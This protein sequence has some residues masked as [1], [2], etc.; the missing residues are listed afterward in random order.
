[1]TDPTACDGQ[2]RK[3]VGGEAGAAPAPPGARRFSCVKCAA[4]LAFQPGTE[5]VACP[6]CGAVNAVP[7]GAGDSFLR[8]NDFLAALAEE[9]R[10]QNDRSDALDALRCPACGAV[11][12][13]TPDRTSDKCPYCGS[14]L[15]AQNR[16]NVKLNVQALLPFGVPSG[17]AMGIYRRWIASRW[18]APADFARRATREQ[19]LDG[20]YMPYWTYDADTA[21]DY[22][23]QRGDVYYALETVYAMENG[24]QVPRQRQV[25][26][27][28]WSSAAGTVRVVFDD[29]LVPATR[30]LPAHLAGRLEPWNLDKLVPFSQDYLAGFVTESYQSSLA[31]GFQEAKRRM[32]P[33]IAD[34]V[35]EDIG[36]DEQRIDRMQTAYANITFKHILLPIWL[37]AYA[38]GGRTYRFMINAQTGEICGDRPWSAWKIALAAAAGL[39]AVGLALYYFS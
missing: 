37:S 31:D 11:T 34:A 4:A 14:A 36:G 29:V 21:T 30:S 20:I 10:R 32:E 35:R 25:P 24:R 2:G 6:Y 12:T 39:A 27:L 23:G 16:Y 3:V 17:R 7:K 5:Q 26:R 28:R 19:G 1:M 13:L 8:E 38:Y 33:V 9:E 15:A 22:A 18:F